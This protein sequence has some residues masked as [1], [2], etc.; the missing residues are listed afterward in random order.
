MS[1]QAKQATQAN[2]KCNNA[3]GPGRRW[4][5][6]RHGDSSLGPLGSSIGSAASCHA[7]CLALPVA[8]W[9]STKHE[10]KKKPPIRNSAFLF[11]IFFIFKTACLIAAYHRLDVD[12]L[13]RHCS[14][15][16]GTRQQTNGLTSNFEMTEK[17]KKGKKGHQGICTVP[18]VFDTEYPIQYP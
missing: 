9:D 2:S 4:F 17:G 7:G 3:E 12:N 10:I 5:D 15:G 14:I 6:W 1:R 11:F 16:R 18:P 8:R 13:K